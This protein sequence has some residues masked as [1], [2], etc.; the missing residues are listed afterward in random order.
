MGF[1]DT[2]GSIARGVG[3]GI[4]GFVTN[5]DV[6]AAAAR[7]G[8]D[9]LRSNLQI[10]GRRVFGPSPNITAV[11]T[12][13]SRF[14]TP[15]MPLI[16][17]VVREGAKAVGGAAVVDV[18][19]RALSREVTPMPV[20]TAM[21]G[22]AAIAGRSGPCLPGNELFRAGATVTPVREFTVMHPVTGRPIVYRNMGRPILYSGDLSA[23]KR[24]QKAARR[25]ARGRR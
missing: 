9:A 5:P 11:Q 21:P 25:A 2:I 12:T 17:P 19:T 3:R 6:Q 16:A 23:C 8:A 7:L 15:T 1:L 22:G 10:N 13:Q 4:E 20:P 24:V 18:L 14:P